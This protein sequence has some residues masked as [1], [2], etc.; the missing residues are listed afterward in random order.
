[1][2]AIR[3]LS[4]QHK[5]EVIFHFAILNIKIRF[6]NT[7]L[8]LLWSA[9]EPMLYFIVLYLVFT[10]LRGNDESFAIYLISG[11]MMYHIF[12]RGTATGLSSLI[13]NGGLIKS[14][15]IRKDFFPV[16]ATVA[17]GLL[18]FVDIGVF[19]GLMPVFNFIPSWTIVLLPIPLVLLLILI[20]GLSY[21]LSIATVFIR[22]VQQ[23][24][25]VFVHSLLFISPIFWFVK[26][27]GPFLLTI[28]KLNPMGQLIEI[29]HNLVIDNKIPPLSEWAYTS[30]Y[31]LAIFAAGY[32]VFQK[33]KDRIAEEL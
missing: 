16:V 22:D 32:F 11:V 24:W 14:L 3:E 29:V 28:Q 17:T 6:R 2:A 19:F 23:I 5:I 30:L 8:G 20:L 9:L 15:T 1:M 33:F 10:S 26:D 18:A 25:N 13:S 27:A 7:Y 31:I 21:L 12:V 4:L